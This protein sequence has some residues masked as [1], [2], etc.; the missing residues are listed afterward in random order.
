MKVRQ[1]I[2]A[3]LKIRDPSQGEG[4]LRRLEKA[5]KD[6]EAILIGQFFRIMHST[7][8]GEGVLTV[9]DTGIG[10]KPEDLKRIFTEFFRAANAKQATP[11]GTGLGLSIVRR[12][13]QRY[14][15]SVA[16][17]ST[18]DEGTTVTVRLPLAETG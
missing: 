4:D 9:R 13:V 12:A 10:M 11:D 14:G 17:D 3:E 8:G 5:A 7:V 16:V 6:F 1:N 18:L 15:G 2:P